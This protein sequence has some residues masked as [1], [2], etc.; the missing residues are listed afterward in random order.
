MTTFKKIITVVLMLALTLTVC[1][2]FGG[3]TKVNET[4]YYVSPNGSDENDGSKNKPFATPEKAVE[5]VR[6]TIAAGLN[7]PVTVYFHAGDYKVT[8]INFTEADSGTAEY[9]VTYKAYGDGDVIFNGG[10]TL[11]NGSFKAVT[12]EAILARLKDEVKDKVKVIDLKAEGLTLEDI[13]NLFVW[14]TYSTAK[15]Y[16][17][18]TV[19]NNCELFWNDERLTIARYPNEGFVYVESV[20]DQGDKSNL[21]PGTVKVDDETLAEMKT[22]QSPGDAWLFG[23]FMFNWADM[24]TPIA[25]VDMNTGAIT[26]K[27]HSTYGYKEGAEY[28]FFNVLEELDAEGEYY[29]DRDNMLLYVYPPEENKDKDALMSVSTDILITGENVSNV[30]FEQI[31]FKGVRNDVI[32]LT[33]DNNT[34]RDCKVMNSYGWGINI[35]GW[36]NL[37]YGCEIGYMGKGG[38][39]MTGGDRA[40]LTPGNNVIENCYI[41]H[42]EEIYRTYQQG[43]FVVGCGNKII[44]NEIAYA[45]HCVLSY[46]GND[47]LIAYNYIH[48]VVY[49]SSDAGALYV[50]GD[51]TS[52][53]TEIKYNLFENI[54]GT[55]GK[56]PKAIYFDDGMSSGIIYGNIV[57]NCSGNAINLGGG[58]DIMVKNNLVISD[59]PPLFYD[60]RMGVDG[61]ASIYYK[62]KP[63]EGMWT[64]LDRVPYTSDLWKERFPRL[65]SITTDYEDY[66]SPDF[67]ANPA[68]SEIENNIF[69]GGKS[70]KNFWEISEAV[71]QYSTIGIN[72]SYAGTSEIL[73]DGTYTVKELPIFLNNMKWEQIPY[74]EIGRYNTNDNAE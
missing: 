39:R 45:P 44:H 9:P 26:P 62:T 65:A 16:N 66:L 34:F 5:A 14:G 73:E 37:V 63:G 12:D 8:N 50:G 19:G 25:S 20:V 42:F 67:P 71:Y 68:Y 47:H 69:I 10:K 24:T 4:A 74:T 35:S 23:Y 59:N 28:Y 29:I 21:I 22:W 55:E 52:C 32:K 38:V 15:Q 60:D 3:C 48:D 1:I 54:G 36:N 27:H 72:Y 58:R 13:G 18:G 17:D 33:G 46:S 43:A 70:A 57:V 41:H 49:E 64:T 61:W 11:A 31:Q 6:E 2:G 7:K 56:Y 53:G 30:T 40:T 51:W